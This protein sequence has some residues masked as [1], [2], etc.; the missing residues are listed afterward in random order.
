VFRRLFQN[1]RYRLAVIFGQFGQ[2]SIKSGAHIESN[3]SSGRWH[4][5]SSRLEQL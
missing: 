3:F 5:T 4:N 2:I 1:V